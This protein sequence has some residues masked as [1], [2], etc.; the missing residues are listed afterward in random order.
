MNASAS[1][2]ANVPV[3][4]NFPKFYNPLVVN[5]TKQAE[6]ELKKRK[7]WSNSTTKGS[8]EQ[9]AAAREKWAGVALATGNAECAA[10]LIGLRDVAELEHDAAAKERAAEVRRQQAEL[11]N[12]LERDYELARLATHTH[13]QAGLG[14][15]RPA[16]VP[17]NAPSG[18]NAFDRT[19]P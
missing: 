8:E 14:A 7:L 11:F 16:S 5:P 10:R 13:Q 17:S 3:P 18:S 1:A 6:L 4:N 19:K 2:A 15:F 9:E 12:A